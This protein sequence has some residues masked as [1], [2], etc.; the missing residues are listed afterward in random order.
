[1]WETTTKITTTDIKDNKDAKIAMDL[2]EWDAFDADMFTDS[3]ADILETMGKD[4]RVVELATKV[5]E[6]FRKR[7]IREEAELP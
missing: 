7:Y 5:K 4:D 6:Q 2:F 3:F 1:L